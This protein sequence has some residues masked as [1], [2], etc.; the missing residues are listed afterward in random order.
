MSCLPGSFAHPVQSPHV[1]ARAP[2]IEPLPVSSSISAS[3]SAGPRMVTPPEPVSTSRDR[4]ERVSAEG[5][6][7]RTLGKYGDW[8]PPGSIVPKKTPVDL[9]STWYYYHDVLIIA[10]L[11][12]VLGRGEEAQEYRRLAESIKAAFNAAYL[13]ESQYAAI[14]V[15]RVD[16]YPNQ[17][18]NVL[19][20]VLDMVPADRKDKVVAS[21]VQSGEAP[22]AVMMS[23]RTA[24][25]AVVSS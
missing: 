17:T 8:C 22:C 6:I 2:E 12:S 10:R 13:G 25:S 24:L 23:P 14:R 15:S 20:L 16:T 9:T 11:A 3:R 1:C 5:H 21:L 19:P 7:I 4:G 18:S